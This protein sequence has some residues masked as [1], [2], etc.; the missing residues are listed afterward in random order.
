[1]T[2]LV[3]VAFAETSFGDDLSSRLNAM[4][5]DVVQV[6]GISRNSRKVVV[7]C[8]GEKLVAALRNEPCGKTKMREFYGSERSPV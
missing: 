2:V 6:V 3:E 8:G 4:R 5:A 7:S 1:M